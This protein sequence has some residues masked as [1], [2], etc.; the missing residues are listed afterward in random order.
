MQELLERLKKV[1]RSYF[2]GNKEGQGKQ[3]YMCTLRN[4]K[5]KGTTSFGKVVAH[6]LCKKKPRALASSYT[7]WTRSTCRRWRTLWT[8]ALTLHMEHWLV[9]MV[10]MGKKEGRQCTLMSGSWTSSRSQRIFVNS[11]L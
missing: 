4:V 3:N 7:A 5:V 8:R 10:S 9:Q 6:V 1:V 11:L 2:L